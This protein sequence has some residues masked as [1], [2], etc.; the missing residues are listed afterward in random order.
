YTVASGTST[1]FG[2]SA[3]DGVQFSNGTETVSLVKAAFQNNAGTYST[4]LY[5]PAMS[6]GTLSAKI[7]KHTDEGLYVASDALSQSVSGASVL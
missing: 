4:S 3:W 7:Y 6:N 2:Y 5:D 1:P